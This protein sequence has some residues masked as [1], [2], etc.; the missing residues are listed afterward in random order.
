[1]RF[2]AAGNLLSTAAAAGKGSLPACCTAGKALDV[3]P[4]TGDAAKLGGML[5]FPRCAAANRSCVASACLLLGKA[6]LAGSWAEAAGEDGAA[7]ALVKAWLAAK[8]RLG[9]ATQ[10]HCF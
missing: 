6:S 7:L 10:D 8:A 4:H 1:L 2:T 9:A 3:L 5:R